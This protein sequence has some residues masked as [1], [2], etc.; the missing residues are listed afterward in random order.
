MPISTQA[1]RALSAIAFI[2]I[3]FLPRPVLCQ[4]AENVLVV[5][6][7]LSTASVRIGEYYAGKR[8]VPAE[9]I[10]RLSLKP[11]EE[12][13]RADYELRIETPVENWLASRSAQDRIL[14]IVLTKGIPHRVSGTAGRAGTLASVDSEL[15]LLYRRLAGQAVAPAGP[16]PNPYFLGEAPLDKA[17]PFTHESQDIY[18]VT[19]LDGFTV[20]EV[21]A[22]IDSGNAPA[23]EGKIVLDGKAAIQEKGNQWLEAA[24]ETLRSTGFRDRVVFDSTSEVVRDQNDVLG[25]YSWGSSDPAMTGRERGLGFVPGAL[26]ATFVSTDARTFTEPPRDWTIGTWD[27]RKGYFAGSPQSLTGD[28]IRQGVTGAAG[29]VAEPYLDGVIRPQILFPAYLAG[30]NLAESFYLSMPYLSWRTVVVGD[31]LCRP[32]KTQQLTAAQID[33]GLDPKTELPSLF[34]RRRLEAA[35]GKGLNLEGVKLSLRAEA[36]LARG[37]KA[38]ARQAFEEATALEKGLTAANLRLAVLYEETGEYESAADRYRRVIAKQPN[39]VVALNNLAYALA[40]RQNTPGDALPLAEKAYTL[41]RRNAAVLDTLGWIYHL[42]GRKSEAGRLLVEAVRLG[43]TNAEIRL[44]A[45]IVFAE[46]GLLDAA[47]REMGK[48]LELDP[49]LEAREDLQQLRVQLKPSAQPR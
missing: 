46:T 45:A 8:S 15:T 20:A 28:T 27:N 49:K 18:L 21:Y 6:N 32:L 10:L 37:D 7:D 33:Q 3:V 16:V 41:A 9:N 26:A 44:H 42:L 34:A 40:V 31:P 29:Q 30:F 2:L 19:R 22:L 35:S 1:P 13:S 4:S 48:A 25:Y 5:I 24:A 39:N 12:I 36:R 14:Y 11:D 43:P 17:K 23:Q 38:G 47:R